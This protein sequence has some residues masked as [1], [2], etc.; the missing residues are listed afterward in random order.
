MDQIESL[1]KYRQQVLAVFEKYE[2]T[3]V[4]VFGSCAR[5]EHKENSDI[6][7]LVKRGTLDAIDMEKWMDQELQEILGFKIDVI[8]DDRINSGYL[9]KALRECKHLAEWP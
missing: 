8:Y 3:N 1:R 4:R 5:L 7:F 2:C 9:E 6:D